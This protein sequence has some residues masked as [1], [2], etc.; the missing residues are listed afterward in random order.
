MKTTNI[1]IGI[2]SVAVVTLS[3]ILF[4]VLAERK[5]QQT[6]TEEFAQFD[7]RT[8]EKSSGGMKERSETSSAQLDEKLKKT[9][10]ASLLIANDGEEISSQTAAREI[11]AFEDLYATDNVKAFH[12]GLSKLDAML[13]KAKQYNTT[14]EGTQNPIIG[15]R[16]YRAIST[17]TLGGGLQINNKF[18]LVIYPTL[19]MDVDLQSGPIYGHTRPCPKLCTQ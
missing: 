2:L 4:R 19:S 6:A 1:L 18:D 14:Q 9:L 8:K 13:T 10:C 7:S 12:M 11:Q 3:I 17:R 16:F 15:F 5:E